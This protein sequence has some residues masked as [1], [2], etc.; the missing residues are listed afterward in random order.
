MIVS[1]VKLNFFNSK[2][3]IVTN[4]L[5]DGWMHESCLGT[6]MFLKRK[7]L[8]LKKNKKKVHGVGGRRIQS[9]RPVDR[10]NRVGGR[11]A[12]AGWQCGR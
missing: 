4:I 2:M 12:E 6:N 1:V 11:N 5:M 7:Q 10:M 9:A 8:H 3:S